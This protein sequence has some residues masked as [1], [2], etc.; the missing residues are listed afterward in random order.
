MNKFYLFATS[1]AI[2]FSACSNDTKSIN[3][4][5]PE[6]DIK[7]LSLIVDIEAPVSKNGNSNYQA[8][9]ANEVTTS[10]LDHIGVHICGHNAFGAEYTT[11]SYNTKWTKINDW[12]PAS[13]IFLGSAHANIYAYYPHNAASE[14][15][16]NAVAVSSGNTDYLF[17][18]AI[19]TA[20]E[21]FVANNQNPSAT[22]K[23][24]HAMSQIIWN[25]SKDESYV[26]SGIVES[27]SL[28]KLNM[29]GTMNIE[30]GKIT[31]SA[32][33]TAHT[34]SPALSIPNRLN[35]MIIPT[36]Y[37]DK[38]LSMTFVI[39]GKSMTSTLG[40]M[41][42]EKGKK[43]NFNIKLRSTGIVIESVVVEDWTEG[44]NTDLEIS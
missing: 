15:N 8:V 18:K 16:V 31:P 32:E 26:G 7:P 30:S 39:D 2:L 40:A 33:A 9:F 5:I 42:F 23:M 29:T 3:P 38:D 27:I 21:T 14:V 44:S 4:E 1:L 13:P 22:V 17:G 19:N 12:T 36:V 11:G 24:K 25:F 43:Y 41:V 35:L 6:G 37:E 20:G 28:N 34:L 10:A